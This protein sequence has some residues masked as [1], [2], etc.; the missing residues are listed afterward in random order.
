MRDLN[1]LALEPVIR[2]FNTGQFD[3]SHWFSCGADRRVQSCDYQNFSDGQITSIIY[4]GYG[5]LLRA[6]IHDKMTT[7]DKKNCYITS[8]TLPTTKILTQ[9]IFWSSCEY[10]AFLGTLWSTHLLSACLSKMCFTI[11]SQLKECFFTQ[12]QIMQAGLKK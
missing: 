9:A 2:S 11:L 10:V 1:E 4:L 8:Q 5:A 3:I 12:G 6:L 7:E